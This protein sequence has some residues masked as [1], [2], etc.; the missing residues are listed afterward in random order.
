[1]YNNLEDKEVI[2]RPATPIPP[3]RLSELMEF[4]K[5]K[6]P[7]HE[8]QRFLCIW[9]RVENKLPPA[10][11]ASI[12]GLSVNTVRFTQ[13]DFINNGLSALTELKRG[14]RIR[15]LMPLMVGEN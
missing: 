15:C 8:F 1:M 7:G 3:Q 12:L 5:K 4:R 14:G 6:W 9:L 10:E 11:I 2:M 13:K